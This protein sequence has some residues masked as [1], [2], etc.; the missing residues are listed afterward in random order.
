MEVNSSLTNENPF[1]RA[2]HVYRDRKSK[3]LDGNDLSPILHGVILRCFLALC[4]ALALISCTTQAPPSGFLSQQEPT[5]RDRKTN[6]QR[7]WKNPKTDFSK[8]R[9]VY[10]APTNVEFVKI[11][12]TKLNERNLFKKPYQKDVHEN[13]LFLQKT[14]QTAFSKSKKRPWHVLERADKRRHA[15]IVESAL[16]E[17]S[18]SRPTLELV[19]TVVRGASV[20]NNPTTAIEVR[21]KDAHSGKI[22]ASFA[23]RKIPPIAV[24]DLAKIRFYKA[25]RNV[26]TR[27][28]LQ[29]VRWL[30][31]NEPSP[32]LEKLPVRIITW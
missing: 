25:Q 6:F 28:G 1:F 14:F 15:L 4:S 31:D 18:P 13:A 22:L 10:V 24:L 26:M 16:V 7:S 21:V 2:I 9:T 3:V 27:W 23:D 11:R 17:L 19:S 32:L 5:E 20:L 12:N 30:N 8:Y 29:T